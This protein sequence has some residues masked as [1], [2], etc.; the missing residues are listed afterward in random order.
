MTEFGRIVVLKKDG[1]EGGFFDIDSTDV[2][3]GRDKESDIRIKNSSVSR[4]HAR[5]SI[6]E[7]KN[8]IDD[9]IPVVIITI[10]KFSTIYISFHSVSQCMLIHLS[11]TN[12]TFVNGNDVADSTVLQHGDIICV[13]ERE[14]VFQNGKASHIIRN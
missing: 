12:P 7:N 1:T 6:D 14:F 5:I 4:L 8:V 11:K 10:S 2:T 13:A 3:F 9:S